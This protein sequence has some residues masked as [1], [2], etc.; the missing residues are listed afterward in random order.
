MFALLAGAA[1]ALSPCVL[2]VLPVA[3]A[4][5]STGGRRRPLGVAVGIAATFA[6]AAVLLTR[7]LDTLGLPGDFARGVAIAVLVGFGVALVVPRLGAALEGRLSGIGRRGAAAGRGDGFGS[8]LV[9]GASLGLVYA[10]CAGPILAAVVALDA[11][12]S[13]ERLALGFAYGAGAATALLAVM[14]L[15]RSLTRRIV[16][17]TGRLQQGFG[18]LM[19]LVAVGLAG[20][21]DRDFQAA[22][23]DDLPAVLVNPSGE[24]EETAAV[25]RSL[26]RLRGGD[27]GVRAVQSGSRL[28]DVGRAPEFRDI[29]SWLNTPAGQEPSL[30]ALRGR[31]VLVDFW[32]YTCI[33]CLRTLSHLRAWDDRYRAAGL[34]IVGVHTPEFA[35]ERR[36]SNVRDA[37]AASRL[38]YPVALDNDYGTWNAWG[39]T[40]WPAKYLID[41]RG[42]VRYSH[43]GEGD[44]EQTERAI[45]ALLAGAGRQPDAG[46]AVAVTAE[47][48]EHGVTTPETYLGWVRARGFAELPVPGTR[49]YGTGVPDP[50]QDRFALRGRW[51]VDRQ[52]A[53]A[54]RGARIDAHVGAR[55]VFL[56]M[57]PPG[58]VRVL[59]DGRPIPDRLAGADV[60]DGVVRVGA[61]RLYRL[62]DFGRVERRVVTLEFERGVAAFAFTF[63]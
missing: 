40:Y 22:I 58:R 45:R 43:F 32:T 37:V 53:V 52:R 6:L 9:L 2:P 61:G 55:R 3:L 29:A 5:G 15:G 11:A 44:Y 25:Q 50:E 28:Q 39:N 4:A 8:G 62:V 54:G 51:R 56:V 18:V 1:T 49:R 27:A 21:A 35:F 47:Q 19:V 12:V 16:P 31:V 13:A 36:E 23:A 42:H 7:A 41:A 48:A 24:L 17:H 14:T 60:H 63:G 34:T 59:L 57:G 33:N 26:A 10:P 30:R 20:G 46:D 38:R